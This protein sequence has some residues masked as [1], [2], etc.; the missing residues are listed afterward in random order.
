MG[1]VFI[2]PSYDFHAEMYR[3][4]KLIIAHRYSSLAVYEIYQIALSIQPK[5]VIVFQ[6]FHVSGTSGRE[7]L[8]W[9]NETKQTLPVQLSRNSFTAGQLF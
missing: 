9:G 7:I 1:S 5:Q 4:M 8:K 2:I 6:G 3:Q